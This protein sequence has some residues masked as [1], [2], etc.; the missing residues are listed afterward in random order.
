MVLLASL[1][2]HS[3]QGY[4]IKLS[5]IIRNLILVASVIKPQAQVWIY[6]LTSSISSIEN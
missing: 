1:E 4:P 5:L 6:K 3:T 2:R